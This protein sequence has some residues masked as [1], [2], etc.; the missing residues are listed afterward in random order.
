MVKTIIKRVL[1]NPRKARGT[2]TRRANP[3]NKVQEKARNLS[4]ATT[5]VVLI[6]LQR[7]AIYADTWSTYTR[8]PLRRSG[9]LKDHLKL[10]SILHPMMLQIQEN[11]NDVLS[12]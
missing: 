3:K 7:S 6:I 9:K 2:S 10:T 8:N 5:M 1:V 12:P 11:P 4:S